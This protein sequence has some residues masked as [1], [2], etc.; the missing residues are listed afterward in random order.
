[1]RVEQVP[2]WGLSPEVEAQIV[3]LL[4]RAF[5][6]DFGGRG[7]F[8]QRH[9]LRLLAHDGDALVG[10]IALLW[11]AIRL[12]DRLVTIS[13]LAEVATDPDRRREGIGTLLLQNAIAVARESNATFLALFGAAG[14]YATA[15]FRGAK[16]PLRW[17]GMDGARLGAVHGEL[18]GHLMV[19]PLGEQE[20]D[21]TAEVDL[22]GSLF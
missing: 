10:H 8:Q 6:T 14:L 13:G 17:I 22:L 2:E 18:S 3:A 5:D 1:M 20:W 12:G 7:F 15:G 19:L 4:A 16:N 21:D 11:R 9:H